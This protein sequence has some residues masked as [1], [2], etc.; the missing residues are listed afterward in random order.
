[1]R[2]SIVFFLL[3]AVAICALHAADLMADIIPPIGLAPGSEYQLIFVTADTT[4]ATSTDITT[5]NS[6]VTTEAGLNPSL[7][8][9]TW[10]AVVSTAT[11]NANV[12]A[13]N[14][15]VDGSYLPV[16]NTQGAGMTAGL[17]QGRPSSM[18]SMPP[19]RACKTPLE[20]DQYRQY[21]GGD[22][23]LDRVGVRRDCGIPTW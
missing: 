5:Y 2:K 20:Y 8:S 1:M 18:D 3:G 7:P 22:R 13:P 16:F 9:A 10:D 11:V 17:A 4:T 12:N 19:K 23:C 14:V 15:M 6:F 21:F